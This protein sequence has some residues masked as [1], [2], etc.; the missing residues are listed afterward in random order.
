MRLTATEVLEG[1]TNLTDS[2][3]AMLKLFQLSYKLGVVWVMVVALPAWVMLPAPLATVPPSGA[4]WA[5]PTA[6]ESAAATS[7]RLLPLPRPRA[8]SATATQVFDVA[9]Q[10]RRWMWFMFWTSENYDE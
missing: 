10:T 4:A 5:R 9:F 2:V 6:N 1:C 8:F 3:A 7:L